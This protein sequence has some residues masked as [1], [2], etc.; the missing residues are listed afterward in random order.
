MTT[1]TDVPFI[2]GPGEGIDAPLARLGTIHK[3]PSAATRGR[4]A[5][6]EHTLPP[7]ALAAPLHR[8]S[9]EDE[10]SIVLEGRLGAMLGEQIVTAEAGAYVLKPRN[11]WHTF[12]NA[13]DTDLR[14]IELLIPGGFEDYFARLSPLLKAAGG[15]PDPTAI[16]SLAD[17]FGIEFDF[18][19]VPDLCERLGLTFG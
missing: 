17:E 7:K 8:H 14:F 5:I 9:R 13:A 11:Q 2:V 3:V 4:L 10:L 6:V 19:S 1:L 12:W 16:Q 15:Q 18:D